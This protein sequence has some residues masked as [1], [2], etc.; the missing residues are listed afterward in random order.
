[1]FLRIICVSR[2]PNRHSC[3]PDPLNPSLDPIST[4]HT[5]AHS[6]SF[7]FSFLYSLFFLWC[8]I[9]FFYF[10]SFIY[11]FFTLFQSFFSLSSSIHLQPLLP[12]LYALP[13]PPFC[14]LPSISYH[15]LLPPFIA[16]PF[17]PLLPSLSILL[18]PPFHPFHSPLP[19]PS[20][21]SPR[22]AI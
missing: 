1:M 3:D 13:L 10:D 19:P 22:T 7:V 2:S 9:L 20:V 8:F 16:L 17:H 11:F 14:T 18:S 21:G 5:R 4:S 12:P 6:L 15:T